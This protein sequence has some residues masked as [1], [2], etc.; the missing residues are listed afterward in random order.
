MARHLKNIWNQNLAEELEFWNR[1]LTEEEF[2]EY[3]ISR[4]HNQNFDIP[5]D[6]INVPKG[7]TI[8]VLDV[9]SG[10]IGK[11]GTIHPEYTVN[12]S[13]SDPLADEYNKLLVDLGM[14]DRACIIKASGEA[15]LDVFAENSFDIVYSANALDHAY[16]PL[17]CIKNMVT[18]CKPG[19]WILIISL[20]NEGE[21]QYYEGL[22]QWNFTLV[23]DSVKLWN[24]DEGVFIHEQLDQV[25]QF[26]AYSVTDDNLPVVVLKIQKL[27]A[28]SPEQAKQNPIIKQP[29]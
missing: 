27:L 14:P 21:R 29:D 12:I 28:S 5:A 3:R 15:L 1:W 22:H 24:R 8:H 26:I 25:K 11:I 16:D 2:K 6:L 13:L 18:V 20:E 10:P 9:G 23:N 19:G 4:L 7:E 17:L